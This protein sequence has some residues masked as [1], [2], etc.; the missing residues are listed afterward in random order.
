MNTWKTGVLINEEPGAG[1]FARRRRAVAEMDGPPKSVS[2]TGGVDAGASEHEFLNFVMNG[3]DSM[4]AMTNLRNS[5]TEHSN[6]SLPALDWYMANDGYAS[7]D[8]GNPMADSPS[9]RPASGAA[10]F[11]WSDAWMLK[12]IPE[13]DSPLAR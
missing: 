10:S 3:V 2:W 12:G 6:V 1:T 9:V 7:A 11:A 8:T 4:N 5:Q 13:L